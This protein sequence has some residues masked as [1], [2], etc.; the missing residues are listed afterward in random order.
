VLE[1]RGLGF[2]CGGSHTRG[3][4]FSVAGRASTGGGESSNT[5]PASLSATCCAFTFSALW[6]LG[7]ITGAASFRLTTA[8]TSVVA[9]YTNGPRMNSRPGCFKSASRSRWRPRRSRSPDGC[10]GLRLSFNALEDPTS[11]ILNRSFE[12]FLIAACLLSKGHLLFHNELFCC[13]QWAPFFQPSTC[14]FHTF[15]ALLRSLVLAYKNPFENK[16]ILN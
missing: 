1:A 14:N 3:L 12:G 15:F 11:P 16:V 7:T 2:G 8:F 4:L 5:T 10:I 13:F 9:S 6:F